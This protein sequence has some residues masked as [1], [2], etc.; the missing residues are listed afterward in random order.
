MLTILFNQPVRIPPPI[1]IT[2]I[3]LFD[4]NVAFSYLPGTNQRQV[5]SYDPINYTLVV[6][7]LN[8]RVFGWYTRWLSQA[9]V[10]NII[11]APDKVAYINF[12]LQFPP[13]TPVFIN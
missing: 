4:I 10:A 5:L 11:S 8:G 9:V 6:T 3:G 13:V 1:A 12:I 2:D 7:Q